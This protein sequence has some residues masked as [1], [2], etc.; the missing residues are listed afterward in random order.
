MTPARDRARARLIALLRLA[1]SGELAAIHAYRGHAR[2]LPDAAERARI[3][4]IEAEELRHREEV[5]RML[6]ALGARP[7]RAREWRAGVIGR[8][9]GLACSFTG[10]FVPLYGAGRLESRNVGEYER[11]ARHA[12]DAGRPELVEPLLAM[13]EVEWEHEAWFRARVLAHPCALLL[14]PW[15]APPPKASIR[16]SFARE[17][18]TPGR[19]EA[20]APTR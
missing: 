12:R 11:A 14:P 17:A 7:S 4:A 6:A 19:A 10:R 5:G 2:S 16:A 9:L 13:A 8:T 18:S 15:P 1:Y 3:G 20:L